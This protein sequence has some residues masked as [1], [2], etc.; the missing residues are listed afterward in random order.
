MADMSVVRTLAGSRAVG[1]SDYLAGNTMLHF[2]ALQ[3]CTAHPVA[4]SIVTDTG[5]WPVS[6]DEAPTQVGEECSVH[7]S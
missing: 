7:I 1:C 3:V 4:I 2:I 5:A 6:G